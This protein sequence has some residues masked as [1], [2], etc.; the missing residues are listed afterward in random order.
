MKDSLSIILSVIFLV[1]LIVIF[2]LYNYFERQDDMTYNIALK[3]VTLFVDEIINNGY[4][5]QNMY[6]KFVSRLGNTGNSYDIQIEAQKKILTI[7][8]NNISP[9][10]GEETYIEQYISYFNKDIF[11]DFTGETSTVISKDNTLKNSAFFL[12]EGDRIYVSIKN[13]NT[14]MASA[15]LNALVSSVPKEKVNISYGGIIKNNNWKNTIVS[16]LFQSDIIVTIQLENP[17]P[18]DDNNGYP[19][20]NFQNAAERIINFKVKVLNAD[21]QNILGKIT[22]N[23]RLIGTNPNCHISPSSIS[24][25]TDE[26]EYI[27]GFKLDETK[28]NTYFAGNEYNVFQCFLPSNAIQGKFSKNSSANSERLIVKIQDSVLIPEL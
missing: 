20:Y 9:S 15:I 17:L 8:P 26:G 24:T 5:D 3:S 23:I 18:G 1:V 10:A 16:Q 14:T 11:D 28:L 4:I 22:D 12:D 27:I 13:T 19:L 2:P 7:D 25:G 6:D 21:D